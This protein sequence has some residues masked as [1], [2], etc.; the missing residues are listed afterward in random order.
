[1]TVVAVALLSIEVVGA[2]KGR[3]GDHL[4][5]CGHTLVT[6]VVGHWAAEATH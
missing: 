5:A 4:T 6:D 1:M 3:V 2:D